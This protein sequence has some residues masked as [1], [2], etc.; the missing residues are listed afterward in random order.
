MLAL[1]PNPGIET[2]GCNQE[3]VTPTNSFAAVYTPPGNR[4]NKKAATSSKNGKSEIENKKHTHTKK[5]KKKNGETPFS[6]VSLPIELDRSV[7]EV[8]RLA[9]LFQY[10]YFVE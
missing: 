5:K 2:D 10:L 1:P 4:A 7:I 3:S 9:G 8:R 6:S